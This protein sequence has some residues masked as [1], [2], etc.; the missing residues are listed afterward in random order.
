[1]LPELAP[2]LVL[3]GLAMLMLPV[4]PRDRGPVR[5]AA[6][7][8]AMAA[9]LRYLVWRLTETLPEPSLDPGALWMWL[10]GLF[11]AASLGNALI[12]AF[13]LLR[14]SNRG[15][16]ADAGEA[17][18][19]ARPE[20]PPVDVAIA[21]YNEPLEVLERSILGALALDWPAVRVWVLDDGRRP[22]LAE[23]C[24]AKGV[25]WVTRA[26]NTHGKAG[27]LNAFLAATRDQ[28]APYLLV[29]DAD[30]VP[31]R[32]ML[33]RIMGFFDDP[34]VALVQTPQSFFN[35]DPI[36]LN[37][38]AGP[39][40]ADEQRFFY[41]DFQPSLDSWGA[42][43]CCGTSFV[44]RRARL[45]AAGGVPTC[46][47]TEDMM[48][49][50][51]LAAGGGRT[52]YLDEPLS[53]G[54]APEGLAAFI[55]QRARWCLGTVQALRSPLQPWK[56]TG[57][58][59][60]HRLCFL[61]AQLFWLGS[62]PLM[63]LAMLAPVVFWWTGTPAFLAS[64][65]DFIAH[66]APRLAAEAVALGWLS[67]WKILPVFS[68]IAPLVVAPAAVASAV[69]ALWRPKG[70]RFKVT[71]KGGGRRAVI[72]HGRLLL[73][74]GALIAAIGLGM[75]GTRFPDL[76]PLAAGRA[77]GVNVGW[78]V[79]ALALL[80]LATLV[81]VEVP[82]RRREER[83][84][85]AEPVRLDGRPARLVDLSLGGASV[86]MDWLCE[87]EVVLDLD[88]IG[89]LPARVV[90]RAKG[91]VSLAFG[92]LGPARDA[93]V[94]KLYTGPAALPP[95]DLAPGQAVRGVLR[96]GFVSGV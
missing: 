67:R 84:D 81:C 75:A 2:T 80:F 6:L 88:D 93:L 32:R 43:F 12:T 37:L 54:L 18:L 69:K 53:A 74:L 62:V 15:A 60:G 57:A 14:R 38:L 52:L 92:D 56:G 87:D 86:A 96:R 28:P 63:L 73:G 4:C 31:Q 11:E 1:M 13:F 70:Q 72:V 51:A 21:T 39:G 48:T 58:G 7:L 5:V 44:V 68:G 50:Y 83:L 64:T 3:L 25:N 49:T 22:W 89:P 40:L 59:W 10:L 35:P 47:V 66:F 77:N 26:D 16:E 23:Y 79:Y 8:V 45:E 29:L 90:R 17:R 91:K 30:F 20:L 42:A 55:T 76:A 24:A 34:G 36:Q 61:N 78:S 94:R 82:R 27:N 95:R 65:E 41:H 33:R 9:M 71:P 19:A 46:T 85:F